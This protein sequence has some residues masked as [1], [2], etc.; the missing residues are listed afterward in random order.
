VDLTFAWSAGDA[1]VDLA[2]SL[3]GVAG[4]GTMHVS[5]SRTVQRHVQAAEQGGWRVS[6]GPGPVVQG[7]LSGLSRTAWLRG[8]VLRETEDLLELP[9]IQLS[10]Q[11]DFQHVID[12]RAYSL[13]LQ[14]AAQQLLQE[15]SAQEDP[16]AA[17]THGIEVELAPELVAA[18]AE[19]D[20]DMTSAAWSGAALDQGVWYR[21][22]ARLRMPGI[23]QLGLTHDVEFA[24]T[25]RVPCVEGAPARS[26]VELVVH[27]SPQPQ[28]VTTLVRDLA[29]TLH[30]PRGL[31]YWSATYMRI[32][33]DPAT[34]T[35]YV[36]DTRRY[37]YINCGVYTPRCEWE[38][39]Q[40]RTLWRST[41][42]R[43]VAAA[44]ELPS[45]S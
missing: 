2:M 8:F 36:R 35:P 42:P 12:E 15:H 37:W 33:V 4:S 31:E 38:G 32:V 20:H 39:A 7:D 44:P 21:T 14:S 18:R 43:A 26:C 29:R 28:E 13:R 19:A 1:N 34:L 23:T 10:A 6:Y 30:L 16:S 24:Y 41:A 17:D 9:D 40:E 3:A 22:Q 25:R 45:G 27:A 5:A 11:G